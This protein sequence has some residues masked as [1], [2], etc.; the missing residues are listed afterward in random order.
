MTQA[1]TTTTGEGTTVE[2]AEAPARAKPR[3]LS[4]TDKVIAARDVALNRAE[5]LQERV[6]RLRRELAQSLRELNDTSDEVA[7]ANLTLPADQQR[8]PTS[9]SAHRA[10]R[11]EASSAAEQLEAGRS[12][13][14]VSNQPSGAE[15][16][17]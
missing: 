11:P 16:H 4:M 9:L 6:S 5:K 15:A 1:T 2:Q 7:R 17:P 14:G 13:N 3:K 10:C 12:P 8:G